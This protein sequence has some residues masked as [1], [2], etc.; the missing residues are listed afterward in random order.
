MLRKNIQIGFFMIAFTLIGVVLV[1]SH[2][3]R[4]K[5]LVVMSYHEL[6]PWTQDVK[7]G[8]DSEIGGR[9]DLKY[10]YMDT[11]R[12]LEGGPRKGKKAYAIYRK[13]QPDGVIA[14]DDNAQ[15]MFVVPYLKDKV[16]APV[17]FCGVNSEPEKY[18]YPA[19]N[20]TGILER[21]HIGESIALAQQLVPSINTFGFIG[22][23]SITTQSMLKQ[24]QHDAMTYPAKLAAYKLPVTMKEAVMMTEELKEQCDALL[25]V[26][27][28]G[29]R[30]RDGKPIN[31]KEVLPVL[32]KTFGKPTIIDVAKDLRYGILCSVAVSGQEQG[33]TAARMLLKAMRGTPVS[34]I[35]IIQNRHGRVMVNVTAMKTLGIKPRPILLR[36][37]ELVKT[38]E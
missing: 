12:N 11:K 25:I 8:I 22:K 4:Y 38:Q 35:P 29:I 16:T 32:A 15:S 6:M 19:S 33:S 28:E 17:M 9:C 30:G 34:Q 27:V 21:P 5:V 18:G 31:K 10:F 1:K 2:A 3:A 20:V 14:V 13:F 24:I 23:D 37:A 36:D 26:N 7:E